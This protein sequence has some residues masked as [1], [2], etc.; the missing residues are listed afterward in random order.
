[1]SQSPGINDAFGNEVGV[2]SL[3][4]SLLP[5]W[6]DTFEVCGLVLKDG[7]I[8]PVR[9]VHEHWEANFQFSIEDLDKFMDSHRYEE[10]LGIYHSHP[11]NNPLPSQKDVL[12]WPK[13][14]DLRYFV[15]T[16][17]RVTEW[18]KDH[19]NATTLVETTE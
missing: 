18:K 17:D 13:G 15:I 10:V 4:D 8:Y 16:K 1:M 6:N 19:D 11:S 14:G 7:A 12:G 3:R 5:L 9:N 2:E